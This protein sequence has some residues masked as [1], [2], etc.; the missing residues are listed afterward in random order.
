[1]KYL[2]IFSHSSGD[3][4]LMMIQY[5]SH[6]YRQKN[7]AV[8]L[9]KAPIRLLWDLDQLHFLLHSGNKSLM[10]WPP[11]SCLLISTWSYRVFPPHWVHSW[12]LP[13]WKMSVHTHSFTFVI[14]YKPL[15]NKITSTLQM[16]IPGRW[17]TALNVYSMLLSV[18][19]NESGKS[20]CLFFFWFLRIAHNAKISQHLII[21]ASLLFLVWFP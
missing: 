3:C 7:V 12:L 20:R 8:T 18:S 13:F 19:N 15:W 21:R 17:V 16:M 11:K 5:S 4:S 1:M 10:K 6:T 2:S 14:L 9:I